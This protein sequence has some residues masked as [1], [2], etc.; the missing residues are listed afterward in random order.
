[1][2]LPTFENSNEVTPKFKEM[3]FVNFK[4]STLDILPKF[5]R[6]GDEDYNQKDSDTHR[7]LQN[8][9]EKAGVQF[10]LMNNILN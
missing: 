6:Y 10:I 8:I 5:E 7:K 3:V 2:Q 1:M 9:C 4:N